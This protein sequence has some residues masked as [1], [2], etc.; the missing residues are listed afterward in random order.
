[1]VVI[2]SGTSELTSRVAT[3]E[4]SL[5]TYRILSELAQIDAPGS[6]EEGS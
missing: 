1:M 6:K 5:A 2:A 3:Q 4:M